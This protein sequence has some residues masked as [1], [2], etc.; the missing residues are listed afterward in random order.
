MAPVEHEPR[1]SLGPQFCSERAASVGA[2]LGPLHK[3]SKSTWHRHGRYWHIP[4]ACS[5]VKTA[6][7]RA[8]ADSGGPHQHPPAD[9]A[10]RCI[11][12]VIP[13]CSGFEIPCSECS[14][15]AAKARIA[16]P[17]RR[18]RQPTDARFP[19]FSRK[20]REMTAEKS[21]PATAPSASQSGELLSRAGHLCHRARKTG[22]SR[23]IRG[24]NSLH[25][26]S[27]FGAF[28]ARPAPFSLAP[29][30]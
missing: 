17:L 10:N 21:S 19:V 28:Q 1:A 22:C 26:E 13:P 27:L 25:S 18:E 14:E 7:Y 12:A 8:K 30:C 4:E 2:Y 15:L 3:S 9:T 29:L 24:A 5:S 11:S 20:I 16:W 23:R 6:A